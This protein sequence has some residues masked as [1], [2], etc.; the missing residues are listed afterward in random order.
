MTF[1]KKINFYR[2]NNSRLNFFWNL[3]IFE[4]KRP[5]QVLSVLGSRLWRRITL[6]NQLGFGGLDNVLISKFSPGDETFS[7]F[8]WK[9]HGATLFQKL[10]TFLERTVFVQL[11]EKKSKFHFAQSKKGMNSYL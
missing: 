2:E 10:E 11:T 7:S 8:W 6:R 3:E 9:V 4:K 1:F 5:R